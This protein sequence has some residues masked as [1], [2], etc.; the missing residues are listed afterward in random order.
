MCVAYLLK[1]SN[2]DLNNM[3]S[4]L[5]KKRCKHFWLGDKFQVKLFIEGLNAVL[6]P[7]VLFL[8]QVDI[9]AA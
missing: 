2:F 5:K 4:M 9:V 7:S 8:C 3:A 6:Y 1:T